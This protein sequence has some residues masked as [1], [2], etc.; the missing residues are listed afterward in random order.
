MCSKQGEKG[1]LSEKWQKKD[2][3]LKENANCP[4]SLWTLCF[5]VVS[6]VLRKQKGATR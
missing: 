3:K 2:R 6:F 1:S 4:D 5:F